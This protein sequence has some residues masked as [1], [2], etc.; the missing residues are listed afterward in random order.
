[1]HRVRPKNALTLALADRFHKGV[2]AT[3]DTHTGDVGR[4]FTLAKGE[5][6]REFYDAVRRCESFIVPQDLTL[7]LLS[8][9]IEQWIELLFRSGLSRLQARMRTGIRHLDR[10]LDAVMKGALNNRPVLRWACEGFGYAISRSRVPAFWYLQTQH[11]LASQIRRELR[12]SG[13]AV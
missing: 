3:T 13:I 10:G 12:A 7:Q 1:M 4:A 2:V 9:E 6:F 5:T 11:N 8:E